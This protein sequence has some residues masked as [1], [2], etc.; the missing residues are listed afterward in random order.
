MSDRHALRLAAI[1]T[2]LAVLGPSSPAT[3]QTGRGTPATP[4]YDESVL[5]ALQYRLVGPFRGGRSTAVTGVPGQPRTF[6]MGTTGGG[7][8]KTTDGGVT[9]RNVS[10]KLR[11]EKPQPPAVVMGE[12]TP[13][14]AVGELLPATEQPPAA[15][16]GELRPRGGDAFGTASVGAIAVAPSD[17]NVVYVGMGSSCIRGNVSPGDGVYKSTDGGETWRHLGLAR[18]QQI[19]RVVVHPDHP[20]LVYVAALGHAFGPNPER[21]V[22][23]SADGGRTWRK[24]LFVSDRAGAVDLV[25]DP[26]N[27]RVLYAATWEAERKPWA[28]NSGGPGS[29]IFKSTDGGDTWRKLSEGLPEGT[30]GRIGLAVSPAQPSRVWALVEHQDKGGLY[31]S[32]DGGRRFRLVGTDRNLITRAWYY[33]HVYADPKD[34]NTVYVLNVAFWRSDDGGRSFIPIRTPHGDNHD[35]WISPDDPQVMIEA[36]DGGANVTYNGGRTWSTQA[37]QPT[38]EMYRVTVDDQFPYWL[39]G[40]Q[41]DNSTVAIPSRTADSRIERQHWYVPGGCESGHVAV[42]PQDPNVTWAGCY[43]GYLGRYDR[44]IGHEQDVT[45]WPQMAVGQAPR[46]LR[47]RFQWNAPIRVSPHDPDVLYHASNHVHRSRDEGMSWET[48]SPDLTRDDPAKQDYSGGSISWDNTGVEVYGTVFA[49]EES[50][51]TPGELW[52]GSDDGLV[53]VSR[54][55]GA[56]WT[57]VT[58]RA[59]PEWATVNAIELSRHASGR[60]FLAVH[61]Y[62]LDDFRPYLFRSDDGGRSWTLLTDGSNGIPVDHFVRVVREDPE[63]KGLLYAGTEF[64]LYVSLDDGRRWQPLQLNLPVAPVTD[65]AVKRGDLVV[66]THGR[67]YWILDDLTALH[68]LTAEVA[69]AGR[70]LFRPRDVY[71]FLGRGGGGGG[72]REATG[73]NP[74]A[75]A[76]IRYLLPE[77]LSAAGAREVKLEILD[78]EGN[79]L[80]TLSSQQEEPAAPSAFARYFPELVQ[81]RKLDARKGMNRYVWNLRLADA[82]VVEDATLWGSAS[83]PEVVPGSYQARLTLA[84]AKEGEEPFVQTQ[85]FAVLADPRR[86]VSPAAEAERYR[87]ARAAWEALTRT[88]RAVQRI[89]DVRA[90]VDGLTK[91]LGDAGMGEGVAEAA[92][93]L[94]EKLAAIADRLHQSRSKASQDIL[95]FPP[96]LDNQLLYVQS[97]IEDAETGPTAAAV[98][99]FEELR[100]QLDT[101]LQALEGVLATDLAAFNALV[102]ERQPPAVIVPKL[103]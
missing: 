24:V 1:A 19:A 14:T 59:M 50:P 79:V 40:G 35:L 93:G 98:E 31:R 48:I 86:P 103:Q 78:S 64:G 36:N 102:A 54:D 55:N 17:P 56:S 61:R 26:G 32:D 51:H 13:D 87:L 63:R 8:W 68:Q 60:V 84:A 20:Q 41:Q 66:A 29:G 100:R 21:G 27:P 85:G 96:Q 70:H 2:A 33:T 44:R 39:Y 67:S 38:A 62:R 57:N 74:P 83:G 12:V 10:D 71:R 4:A 65:L 45:P 11:E 42:D 9:W 88:H 5:Q 99:R 80:R 89:R 92:K 53:H 37:N 25:I 94:H 3:P 82:Y 52:A 76:V 22:Y 28:M 91:R 43:G 101:E 75:G 23:R 97:A 16:T 81:P 73:E 6:Y 34:A 90:Q 30:L 77:D 58:P 7:V 18:T 72:S 49:L 46:D 69:A 15:T 95:N 47:Y